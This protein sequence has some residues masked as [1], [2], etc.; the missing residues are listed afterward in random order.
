[1]GDCWRELAKRR[2]VTLRT[3]IA[4]PQQIDDTSF[5]AAHELREL[6]VMLVPDIADFHKGEVI[7]SL[8]S[9]QPDVIFIVGWRSPVC[10]AIA[11][12]SEL[13][14]VKKI[15]VFDLPFRFTV[16]KLLAPIVLHRYLKLF[17]GAFVPGCEASR[18]ACWLGFPR[19]N[20]HTGLFSTNMERFE[21]T[22]KHQKTKRFLYVGRYVKE[23]GLD[24]LI[25]AYGR[26]RSRVSEP[27]GLDC[28]GTGPLKSMFANETGVTDCGFVSPDKLDEVYLKHGVFILPSKHEPWGVVL[29]EACAAGLPIIC[30]D[31]CGGRHEL[32][33]GNGII[34]PKGNV[35]ALT[36]AIVWMHEHADEL[37]E[38]GFRGKALA[39]NYSCEAWADRVTGIA[40]KVMGEQNV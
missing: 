4:V 12:S 40:S 10:R 23:K 39:E 15:I 33:K 38:M 26:Y 31:A 1:M 24:V 32:V 2:G 17:V 5:D 34:F 27:W 25:E 19:E 30:S 20:V 8:E 35:E 13:R 7:K 14:H 16:R 9:F 37:L 28:A 11:E 36:D 21:G 22:P 3:V 29:A 18:Y 6:D